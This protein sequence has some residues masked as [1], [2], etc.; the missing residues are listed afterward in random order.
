MSK[1]EYV[2]HPKWRRDKLKQQLYLFW[3]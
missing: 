1:L 2:K 3:G